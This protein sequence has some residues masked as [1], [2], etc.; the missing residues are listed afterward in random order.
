VGG[1]FSNST[2][3]AELT[4][5]CSLESKA[6]KIDSDPQSHPADI[7]YYVTDN[8]EVMAATGWV[9]KNSLSKTFADVQEWLRSHSTL[10]EPI[11]R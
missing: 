6:I 7:P 9:Q 10:L 8:T 11:L 1:G 5:W 4:D 3:L 2:S